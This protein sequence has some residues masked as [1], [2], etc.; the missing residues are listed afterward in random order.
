MQRFSKLLAAA[1]T[2]TTL[3]LSPT[4]TLAH[5]DEGGETPLSV[6]DAVTSDNCA[7]YETSF[8]AAYRVDWRL[9]AEVSRYAYRVEVYS[10]QGV[11]T[12]FEVAAPNWFPHREQPDS[13]AHADILY[14]GIPT[15]G[16][17]LRLGFE[18]S[19]SPPPDVVGFNVKVYIR[20]GGDTREIVYGPGGTTSGVLSAAKVPGERPESLS[21]RRVCWELLEGTQTL[22]E[23]PPSTRSSMPVPALLGGFSLLIIFALTCLHLLRRR[24]R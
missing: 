6:E 19:V 8:W 1:L 4:A 24:R 16:L 10:E 18:A 22:D 13:R 20:D 3:L 17:L 15:A 5:E 21:Y 2:A 7:V 12:G 23:I 11:V 14:E 9:P